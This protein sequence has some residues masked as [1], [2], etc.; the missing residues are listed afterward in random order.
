M[1]WLFYR[2]CVFSLFISFLISNNTFAIDVVFRIDDYQLN[3]DTLN[4]Q[5]LKI[6]EDANIPLSIA[7]IPCDKN[8]NFVYEDS[9][10]TQHICSFALQEKPLIEIALHGL[11]H[12]NLANGE[13]GAVSYEEQVRRLAKGKR[14]LDSCLNI[15]RDTLDNQKIIGFIPPFN[16]YDETTLQILD[17]LGFKWISADMY[18]CL[19]ETTQIRFYPESFGAQY[20]SPRTVVECLRQHHNEDGL[21]VVMMH[22]YDIKPTFTL[23]SL[24]ACLQEINRLPNV[25][26]YTYS[27]VLGKHEGTSTWILANKESHLL[28]KLDDRMTALWPISICIIWRVLN[29]LLYAV[30]GLIISLL[31]YFI[32]IRSIQNKYVWCVLFCLFIFT[33][34]VTWFKCLSP[35]KLLALIATLHIV[36]GL[37]SGLITK[38]I[39]KRAFVKK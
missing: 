1:K 5:I 11:T 18:G 35:L 32:V 25:H 39:H 23:D 27:E 34:I 8:E 21:V 24:R 28:A 36:I 33:F 29:A 19:T 26:Y 37:L 17:S 12:S 6:F 4:L 22:P 16:S 15:C 13:F 3:N 10:L 38:Q 20:I 30:L 31:L 14:F 9:P 7:V 2:V